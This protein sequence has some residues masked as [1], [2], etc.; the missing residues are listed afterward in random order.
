LP[1]GLCESAIASTEWQA[2]TPPR[3]L[4][5]IAAV[6]A[7]RLDPLTQSVRPW[8][9]TIDAEGVGRYFA[10]K[11]EAIAAVRA[12]QA[13]GVQSID[14]GCMQVNLLHHPAAF[15]DLNAA[16]E[17]AE[18]VAYAARFLRRLFAQ[19]GSW[20]DAAAAY[21][22]QTKGIAEPYRQ[23]VLDRWIAL[24]GRP[25][26]ERGRAAYAALPARDAAYRAFPPEELSYRA[27]TSAT[28]FYAAFAQPAYLAP[29]SPAE[30]AR[31]AKQGHIGAG[32]HGDNQRT[33]YA[34]RSER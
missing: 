34:T 14:V 22:S 29:A 31:R 7:G 6:E 25:A 20:S 33:A 4:A 17:P 30:A 28:E 13:E 11:A 3:L 12:L 18:N 5:A 16:F 9:W 1:A 8:P 19:T 2:A 24:A 27:F 15:A 23:R 10:T 21:H 26:G 32:A